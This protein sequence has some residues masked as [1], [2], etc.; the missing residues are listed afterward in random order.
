MDPTYQPENFHAIFDFAAGVWLRELYEIVNRGRITTS[1]QPMKKLIATL[2]PIVFLCS[3]CCT[4]A[5]WES[6]DPDGY[7]QIRYTDVTEQELRDKKMDFIQ[8]DVNSSYYVPKSNMRKLSEYSVRLLATPV[9][10]A[11]DAALIVI[12]GVAFSLAETTI[13]ITP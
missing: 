8:D 3:S 7:I 12:S 9:T 2:L 11:V 13:T 4:S 5:L 10:V 1:V 6:Y